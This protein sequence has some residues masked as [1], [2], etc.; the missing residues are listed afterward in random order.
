MADT[1][2]ARCIARAARVGTLA[3]VADGQPY[4]SL[5]TPAFAAD[6]SIIL[7][8]SSLS[9]HTRQLRAEPRCALLVAGQ[10]AETNPQTTPRLTITATAAPDPDPA[11]RSRFL[12]IHPYAALYADFGDF[13]FWRLT[14]GAC[15]L[16]GGFARAVRLRRDDLLPGPEAVAAIAGSESAIITHCNQD[17]AMTLAAIAGTTEAWKMVGVDIDG[18]DLARGDVVRRIAW[19][20]PVCDAAGVRAAL[21]RLAQACAAC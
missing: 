12:A 9:E 18:C 11:L 16:V 3:T 5:V 1:F 13:A 19:P 7:L 2:E 8:L 10:P 20:E 14:P 21:I 6:F 4:A 17:H 15:Q